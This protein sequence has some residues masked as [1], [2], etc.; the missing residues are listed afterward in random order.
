MLKPGFGTVAVVCV[1]HDG[2]NVGVNVTSAGIDIK[3]VN[4]NY[5]NYAG[6]GYHI[7]KLRRVADAK[8]SDAVRLWTTPIRCCAVVKQVL[9]IHECTIISPYQLFKALSKNP[10]KY[11]YEVLET[12]V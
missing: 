10:G 9:K 5:K 4:I 11:G 8:K 1:K 12:I 7:L 3:L 2:Y 6:K